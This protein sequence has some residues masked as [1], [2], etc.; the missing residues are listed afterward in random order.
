VP[1]V[2]DPDSDFDRGEFGFRYTHTTTRVSVFSERSPTDF[3]VL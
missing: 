1:L 3:E 2:A